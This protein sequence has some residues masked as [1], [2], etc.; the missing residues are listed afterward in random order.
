MALVGGEV[1]EAEGALGG[2]ELSGGVD[3][4]GE[5]VDGE[6]GR[7]LSA[8]RVLRRGADCAEELGGGPVLPG[9]GDAG[10][11]LARGAGDVLDCGE[12]FVVAGQA[13][14]VELIDC[15][16]LGVGV[17]AG[18]AEE[19][20]GGGVA[21]EE[22]GLELEGGGVELRGGDGV[23]VQVESAARVLR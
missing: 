22:G 23:Q 6:G 4:L 8:V 16:G 21:R 1:A 2:V 11:L 14:V 17:G 5:D 3:E 18:V 13:V 19:L 7:Y 15:L 10:E 20:G 9:L 12:G